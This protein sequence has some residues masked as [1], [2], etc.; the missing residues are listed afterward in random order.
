M[1]WRG[2][3]AVLALFVRCQPYELVGKVS[4]SQPRLSSPVTARATPQQSVFP[5]DATMTK[6]HGK[7]GARNPFIPSIPPAC[8]LLEWLLVGSTT[9]AGIVAAVLAVAHQMGAFK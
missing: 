6:T 5:L 2:R 4:V 3:M 1:M 9:V 8:R 7:I